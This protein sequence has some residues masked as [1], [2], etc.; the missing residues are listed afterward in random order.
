MFERISV[1]KNEI[2]KSQKAWEHMWLP[3]RH[4]IKQHVEYFVIHMWKKQ[5]FHIS[6]ISIIIGL[7]NSFNGRNHIFFF[8]SFLMVWIF[9][10]LFIAIDE[11]F[12]ALFIWIYSRHF[13][14]FIG[15]SE[16]FNFFFFNILVHSFT[17]Q[18]SSKRGKKNHKNTN[19]HSNLL[20]WTLTQV[21]LQY[22]VKIPYATSINREN[23]DDDDYSSH[24]RTH[25][26]TQY[27]SNYIE[28]FNCH[29]ANIGMNVT[30]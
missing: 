24:I 18:S 23:D 4:S 10:N 9:G 26:Y 13:Y 1:G 7:V 25:T 8:F 11:I 20:D 15:F 5:C 28:M 2:G 22:V 12:M 21:M 30:E 19:I 3:L 29:L 14:H 17:R 6:N 16:F 27:T